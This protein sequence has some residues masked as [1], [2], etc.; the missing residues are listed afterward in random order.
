[1]I[2]RTDGPGETA[3]F[4]VRREGGRLHVR[5][6]SPHPWQ[7]RIGGHDGNLPTSTAGLAVSDF[8]FEG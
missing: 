2:P 5:T 4:R 7:P 1:V 6:D 8:A 3:R